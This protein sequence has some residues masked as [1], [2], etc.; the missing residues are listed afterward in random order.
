M[1]FKTSKGYNIEEI[2]ETIQGSIMTKIMIVD[3]EKEATD[4]LENLLKLE[5][6]V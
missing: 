1:F 5:G 2:I 6:Y 3:D 4:L